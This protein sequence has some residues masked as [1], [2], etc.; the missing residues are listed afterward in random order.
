M[1]PWGRCATPCARCGANTKSRRSSDD[2]GA[3]AFDR[4]LLMHAMAVLALALQASPVPAE[5]ASPPGVASSSYWLYV[6]SCGCAS[7]EAPPA[8][9]EDHG[10][11]LRACA[12]W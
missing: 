3:G 2:P 10:R 8:A 4:R 12:E 5:C 1:R 11:F 9:S 7:L 6:E